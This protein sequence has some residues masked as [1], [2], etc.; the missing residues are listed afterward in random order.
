MKQAKPTGQVTKP[1][2]QMDIDVA[3]ALSLCGGFDFY[4]LHLP[5]ARSLRPARPSQPVTIVGVDT[6]RP[7][8]KHRVYCLWSEETKDVIRD[9]FTVHRQANA[10]PCRQ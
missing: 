2:T 3:E 1:Q 9:L 8:R 10:A 6:H 4:V 7:D 5:P